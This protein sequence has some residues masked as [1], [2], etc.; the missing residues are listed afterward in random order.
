VI[1]F[2]IVA[3]TDESTVVAEYNTEQARIVEILDKFL[4]FDGKEDGA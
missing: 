4:T 2:N 1:S 3:S